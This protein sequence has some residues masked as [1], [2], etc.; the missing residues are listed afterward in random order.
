MIIN[1][2][3][4]K[5][6]PSYRIKIIRVHY[7]DDGMMMMVFDLELVF[8]DIILKIIITISVILHTQS[9]EIM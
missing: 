1:V 5:Y 3:A 6:L 2:V 8:V 7:G 4:D 9:D